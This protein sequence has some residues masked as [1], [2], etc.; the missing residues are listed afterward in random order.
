M[1]T[2]NQDSLVQMFE[3]QKEFQKLLTGI[4][5]PKKDYTQL[6]YTMTALIAELGEVLQAD[7]NWKN[8]K[9][10]KDAN[11]DRE[12]LL[13]EVVDVY[14]FIINMTL[15]LGFDA[16]DVI[17]KFFEKNKVNFERQNNNY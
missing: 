9:R 14:H 2:N 5:L 10:T 17:N 8:W 4:E 3:K 13:D 16:N 6:N 7:K 1:M 12:A 11:V 15:Y